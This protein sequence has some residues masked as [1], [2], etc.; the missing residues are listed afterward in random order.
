MTTLHRSDFIPIRDLFTP[1][2][3][4]H[5][6]LRGFHRTFA[7]GVA[8][9]QGTLTPPCHYFS[10]LCYSNIT[11][12]FLDF[13]YT[14]LH[15]S[16]AHVFHH[17]IVDDIAPFVAHWYNISP[18]FLHS[19]NIWEYVIQTK[20]CTAVHSAQNTLNY[21]GFR[22]KNGK[23]SD[24]VL[25]TKPPSN[26]KF[27]QQNLNSVW[28]GGNDLTLNLLIWSFVSLDTWTSDGQLKAII[29]PYILETNVFVRVI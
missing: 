15:V 5:W 27:K 4:F 13:A 23:R 8:C 21:F 20:I 7:T 9:W 6:L 19:T 17:R 12:Y 29:N 18:S 16:N 3:T 24:P 26:R 14:Y 11:R 28:N 1:N 25:W 22:V 10:G 2:S